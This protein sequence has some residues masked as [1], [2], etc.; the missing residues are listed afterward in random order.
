MPRKGKYDEIRFT[1]LRH[2][3]T[4]ADQG[5]CL[6]KDLIATYKISKQ[7]ASDIIRMM[8]DDG[9]ITK[10]KWFQRQHKIRI[11]EKG[12]EEYEKLYAKGRFELPYFIQK[13]FSSRNPTIKT[14]FPIQTKFIERGLLHRRDNVCVFGY[15]SSGKTLVAEMCM[16][17]EIQN[18]GK[19]LYC[20]PYK[21]LDWQK[22]EDFSQSFSIFPNTK[23]IIS[24]GD[25]RIP[26]AELETAKIVIATY[27]RVLGAVKAREKWLEDVSLVC[28]DEITLL[29]DEDRGG[30]LDLLLTKLRLHNKPL[31]V[32]TLSSLVGNSLQI[33]EWL[34][35][36]PVIDN[37]SQSPVETKEYL[38]YRTDEGLVIFGKDGQ[39]RVE[40][41]DMRPLEYIIKKNLD[42]NETTLIFV[43]S[44]PT[45][46]WIAESLKKY[47]K[48]DESLARRAQEFFDKEIVEKTQLTRKLIELTGY[49]I[50]FHH[51]GLQ[52]KA[53][54][55]VERL[56]R[57]GALRTIVATTTLSHGVDY[58]IDNVVIDLPGIM[59]VHELYGYEYINLKGRTGRFG[60]SKNA[61]IYILTA[62]KNTNIAFNKYFFTSPEPLTPPTTFDKENLSS[63]ILMEASD[64]LDIAKIKNE[65][66]QTLHARNS[67]N[68]VQLYKIIRDLSSFGFIRKTSEGYEITG[69]GK[70]VNMANL[71]PYD[72]ARVL[73]LTGNN[74]VED[75]LDLASDIDV[76]SRVRKRDVQAKDAVNI[77]M[78]WMEEEP[79]DQIRPKIVG[80]YN[81]HD[82]IELTEYTTTSLRKISA[83]LEDKK[84]K[85]RLD[86]LQTRVKFGIRTDLAKSNLFDLPTLVKSRDRFF[87]RMMFDKGIKSPTILAK[88][89]P[90]KLIKILD[91]DESFANKLINE[92]WE[93]I[94]KQ[95][96]TKKH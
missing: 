26:P 70:R 68:K 40:K 21:A 96:I 46:E 73:S 15:P 47:H 57:E 60:K 19:V 10:T 50:A 17:N 72:A 71:M 94:R 76:A 88:I 84:M 7:S 59:Q 2:L 32:L 74:N 3:V 5:E 87:A 69:L 89:N 48:F 35:A 51:A 85:R 49:D 93:L 82:I 66:A 23:V 83:L 11:T 37:R 24:D 18:G 27:E 14:L 12:R 65:L 25:N 44:R 63:L 34:N 20:T 42:A 78:M 64:K 55:F 1:I 62:K 30:T 77:L 45:T 41:T 31:R 79:I 95:T 52:R 39:K 4:L 91:V 36:E 43:G 56:L 58:S 33:A 90:E 67:V 28:A 75:I 6:L 16:V 53:R 54:K 61:N 13:Y 29:A 22:Y 9:L 92:A 8:L 38:F 81:D 86:L 80:N